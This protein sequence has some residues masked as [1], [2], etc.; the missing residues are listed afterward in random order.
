MSEDRKPRRGS[1]PAI[2]KPTAGG[3]RL[4]EVEERFNVENQLR[5]ERC[6]CPDGE[7]HARGCPVHLAWVTEPI[8]ELPDVVGL[9]PTAG[10]IM[11]AA[12]RWGYRRHLGAA[13]TH[14][15]PGRKR[16]A[17]AIGAQRESTRKAAP[18]HDPRGR[19]N[20]ATVS[21]NARALSRA[22][23]VSTGRRVFSIRQK[24]NGMLAELVVEPWLFALPAGAV[25]RLALPGDADYPDPVTSDRADRT[26]PDSVP[27]A[28]A[29]STDL[30]RSRTD[31]GNL[32]D[33]LTCDVETGLRDVT[34]ESGWTRPRLFDLVV[35]FVGLPYF[36]A[37]SREFSGGGFAAA[38]WFRKQ[39]DGWA[40]K[41]LDIGSVQR[42]LLACLP[43]FHKGR[44][45][46]RK[47]WRATITAAVVGR[48][49]P[50]KGDYDAVDEAVHDSRVAV[51]GVRAVREG[52]KSLDKLDAPS[53]AAVLRVM[54]WLDDRGRVE[55]WERR[56]RSEARALPGEA[57]AA[58]VGGAGGV[59]L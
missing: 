29:G 15:A 10:K 31:M 24:P 47:G 28:A 33:P 12:L 46:V 4:V 59:A 16:L 42:S 25:V 26:G 55:S 53:R 39:C 18:T 49:S 22:R 2:L 56:T 27:G 52:G 32:F 13:K 40:G 7:R 37:V 36:E 3:Y 48:W 51:E 44:D 57:A 20:V 8:A 41:G 17:V 19:C 5:P 6:S 9:S 30:N 23:D 45:A 21:R 54:R 50:N 14:Y 35:W 1:G 34:S 43:Y 38:Q 58:R 11:R